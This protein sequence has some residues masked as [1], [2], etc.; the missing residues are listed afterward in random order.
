VSCAPA[1]ERETDGVLEHSIAL[2]GVADFGLHDEL[3]ASVEL[4]ASRFLHSAAR[5]ESFSP[6]DGVPSR[7][8][9]E[10]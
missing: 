2:E 5:Q 10:R 3:S 7:A 4:P 8:L 1:S 6:I 9:W